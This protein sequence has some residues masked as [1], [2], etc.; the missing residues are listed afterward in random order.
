MSVLFYSK[1]FAR[2]GHITYSLRAQCDE[3][4][5]YYSCMAIKRSD[6]TVTARVTFPAEVM[7]VIFERIPFVLE[8]LNRDRSWMT[9]M[10]IDN[11]LFHELFCVNI[12]YLDHRVWSISALVRVEDRS[13][14]IGLHDS[15]EIPDVITAATS[16]NSRAIY[17]TVEALV[18]LQDTIEE[19]LGAIDSRDEA[20]GGVRKLIGGVKTSQEAF[21]LMVNEAL[22]HEPLEPEPTQS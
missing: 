6:E 15:G 20:L 11:L 9:T 1:E 14:Y 13:M 16:N 8:S 17:Y 4:N 21:E 10:E 5:E 18:L 19:A 2:F 7:E 12:F 22:M 3:R